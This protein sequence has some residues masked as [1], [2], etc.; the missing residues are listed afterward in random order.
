LL[1]R[2]FGFEIVCSKCQAP[3]RLIALIQTEDI[4][5]KILTA[6][7]LPADI[8]AIHSARSPEHSPNKRHFALTESHLQN[9]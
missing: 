3:L 4:A 6:M 8:P 9:G 5:K 1:R 7:H 2:T